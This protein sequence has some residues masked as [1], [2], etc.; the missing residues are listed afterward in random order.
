MMISPYFS[1]PIFQSRLLRGF[2][3]LVLWGGNCRVN[4]EDVQFNTDVLDLKKMLSN[5]LGQFSRS[6]YI[7]PG[8]YS[9]AVQIKLIATNRAY[10]FTHRKM[11]RK[12]VKPVFLPR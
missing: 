1:L 7:M 9:M 3:F 4:A 5:D 8:E 11:T 10:R 2:I 12:A 6:G